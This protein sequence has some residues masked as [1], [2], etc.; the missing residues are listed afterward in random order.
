[1]E[2]WMELISGSEGWLQA[3]EIS[4]GWSG[5]RKFRVIRR[6]GPDLL[7]RAGDGANYSKM[8]AIHE[9]ML[10]L[11]EFDLP[12][13]RAVDCGLT[14]DGQVAWS[15]LTYIDGEDA[16]G[17]LPDMPESEQYRLG[18]EAGQVLQKIHSIPAPGS[19]PPWDE[20]FNAKIDRKRKRWHEVGYDMPGAQ[21]AFDYIDSNRPLLAGRPQVLQHGDYHCGNMVVTPSGSVGVIDFNRLD[22]GDPWEEFNRIVWDVR[23]SHAFA[24]GRI[25][26]Y[27]A[28]EKPPELFWQLLA[29]YVTNDQ[30]SALPWAVGFGEG[31][32]E[33]S[34]AN[35]SA[36]LSW[37]DNFRTVIP[38]WYAEGTKHGA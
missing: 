29:L 10:P 8:R 12:A 6:D 27:F 17:A 34:K 28:P 22:W 9:A 19:R 37:Y 18:F 38:S 24:R 20:F 15:L 4:Y 36:V 2:K 26:G 1:M 35:F 7:L 30:V 13:S 5:E 21:A 23:A 14:P 31:E 33:I 25:D 32:L 16:E 3:Q 11:N